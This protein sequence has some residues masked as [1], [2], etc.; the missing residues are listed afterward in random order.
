VRIDTV[1]GQLDHA[2][3]EEQAG[4]KELKVEGSLLDVHRTVDITKLL[5]KEQ[6][7]GESLEETFHRLFDVR[8]A[9]VDKLNQGNV[10]DAATYRFLCA[11]IFP[12]DQ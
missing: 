6:K 1:Y 8:P 10:V 9:G 2:F 12:K 7:P 4:H 11:N 3:V 5:E